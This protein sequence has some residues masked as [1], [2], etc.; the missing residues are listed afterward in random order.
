MAKKVSTKV[1]KRGTVVIPAET[2]R[3]YAIEEGSVLIVA[4]T[5]EGILLQPAALVPIETYSP[6][7]KAEFLL[8]NAVDDADYARAV[9]AV[10]DLGLDPDSIPHLKPADGAR[11]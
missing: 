4:E 10:R 1:G 8:S 2:R 7:R 9:E 5:D 6:E 3:R 11:D